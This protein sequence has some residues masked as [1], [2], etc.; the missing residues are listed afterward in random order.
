MGKWQQKGGQFIILGT[1]KVVKRAVYNN[2][3]ISLSFENAYHCPDLSHNLISISHLNK[4][5][6][7]GVFGA[8]G[9]TFL[10]KSGNPF[11]W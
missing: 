1:G 3:I 2:H 5:G 9:V 4:A 6:C 11:V 8:R 7:F 10:N